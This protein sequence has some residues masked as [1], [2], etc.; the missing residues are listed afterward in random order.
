MATP[1]LFKLKSQVAPLASG[2]TAEFLPIA[3][4]L[5]DTGVFHLDQPYDYQI[6]QQLSP[7]IAVGV[8]VVVPFGNREVEGIVVARNKSTESTRKLKAISKVSTSLPVA[9][10]ALLELCVKAAQRWASPAW[11][12]FRSAVPPRVNSVEKDF[13]YSE[14][15]LQEKTISTKEFAYLALA[16]YIDPAQQIALTAIQTLAKGSVLLIAPDVRDVTNIIDELKKLN[17]SL[18]IY[19]LDSTLSRAERYGNYLHCFSNETKIVVGSR[20]AI[21]A[22]ISNLRTIIIFKESSPQHYE[23]RSPAWNCRDVAIMRRSAESI[24]LILSGYVP[25][26]EVAQLIECEELRYINPNTRLKVQALD[27]DDFGLLPSRLFP[28]VRKALESGPVLFILP[29]K[30][31]GNALLCAHCKNVAKCECGARL[32]VLAKGANPECVLCKNIFPQWKCVWCKRDKQYIAA[33]GIDRAGEEIGRAFANFSVITSSGSNILDRVSNRP[34]LVLATPGAAPIVVEGYSAVVILEGMRFF[35]HSDLRA[36]ERA[37]E[38]F[39]QSSALVRKNGEVLIVID[40]AHPIIPALAKWNPANL[41]KRELR[42]REEVKL[43]PYAASI[44]LETN[45]KECTV[46]VNGFHNAIATKRLAD[47]VRILGPT[48]ISADGAKITIT[49][50]PIDFQTTVAF[51]HELQRRR[52]ISKK[53]LFAMRVTPYSLL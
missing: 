32:V 12:I 8:K 28:R 34:A 6:S 26:I 24:D 29:T 43:P 7:S 13:V 41:L 17:V 25:S 53:N 52:S 27:S 18:P 10:L 40:S 46:I 33:R 16:P 22:P 50:D 48:A 37:R 23:I 39:F 21:F 51:I 47:S 3:S 15:S 4:V 14:E 1:R 20:S 2:P 44:L 11:D 35:S 31:Y 5:V 45:S 36:D 42:E 19:R 9:N 49:C 38:I 30:G